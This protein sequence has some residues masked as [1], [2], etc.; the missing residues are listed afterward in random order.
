M[1]KKLLCALALV[2]T[3]SGAH[4]AGGAFPLEK[5]PNRISDLAALQNGAKLFVNYCLNC[6][7]AS[8]MRYNKLKDIGLTDQQIRESLLFTGEKV[9]DLMMGSVSTKDG[10]VWFG[11]APPDLSVMARAKSINAGPTGSDY[12]YTYLRTYY[13]DTSKPTGWDNLAFPNS[14]MPHVLWERQG[15]RELTTTTVH[16]APAQSGKPA[17]WE[18]IVTTFEF[19]SKYQRRLG[20]LAI[21]SQPTRLGPCQRARN[22]GRGPHRPKPCRCRQPHHRARIRTGRNFQP[23]Q[24]RGG[25][26]RCQLKVS[27]RIPLRTDV[28]QVRG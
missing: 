10:K 13:R 3:C 27:Q 19:R 5:A 14:G 4:A 2:I 26:I 7:S 11:A 9:G 28:V 23:R 8:A 20:C 21:L 6:H 15:L 18:R 12:I 25:K 24:A 22:G 16:Q 1:I 17:G